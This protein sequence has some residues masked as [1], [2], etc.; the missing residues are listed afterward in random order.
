MQEIHEFDP[1]VRKIPGEGNG[2]PL[3]YSCMEN[4]TAEEFGGL[5]SVGSQKSQ[6]RLGTHAHT[7]THTHTH[8]HSEYLWIELQERNHKV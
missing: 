7:H 3:Q 8:T 6:T 2:N 1:W 5:Q 4:S